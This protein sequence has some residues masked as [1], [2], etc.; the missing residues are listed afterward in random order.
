MKPWTNNRAKTWRR[1]TATALL[2]AALGGVA[3]FNE[4][5]VWAQD[6]ATDAVATSEAERLYREGRALAFGLDGRKI[7]QKAG[8]EKLRKAAELGDAYATT[9][10]G[11]CYANG[12]GV[13][14]NIE[15][16]IRWFRKAAELG[17]TNAQALLREAGLAE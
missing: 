12:T 14:E 6:A 8:V 15:E 1:S 11:G 5:N 2:A 13:E 4:A 16:A 7:D 9:N 10:L 3:T 17:E